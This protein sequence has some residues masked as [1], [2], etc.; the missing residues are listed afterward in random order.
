MNLFVAITDNAWFGQLRA[1]AQTASVAEVNFWR[2]SGVPF[3]ALAVGEP[4]LFK[5][6]APRHVIAGGG[7]FS[8]ASKLS[9]RLAW[10]AFGPY[11]G[12]AS[13]A[14]LRER[15]RKYRGTESDD[16]I[17]CIILS[18]PFFFAPEGCISVPGDFARNLQ[19]GRGYAAET[20]TGRWLYDQVGERLAHAAVMDRGPAQ[21]ALAEA[22]FG[23]PQPVAP[24]LGQGGFRVGML[25]NYRWRCAISGERTVPVLEA[26]HIR[27]YSDGG[28]HDLRNGLLLRS[29][30]HRLFDL[31]YIAIAPEDRRVLVSSRI[32]TEFENGRNY[33][34]LEGKPLATPSELGAAP[35][36]ES[37]RFH[38]EHVYRG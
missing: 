38:L 19:T 14:A 11:N 34:A 37:L 30:L 35:D 5:L 18:E 24:R 29:D 16:P 20:G 23:A 36:P 3:R 6:H 1:M 10:E 9:V 33:Y 27:R 2:P 32:R 22:R 17:T 21:F 12:V 26:A 13:E 8:R 15:I 7:F 4:L 28:G 31:G 25:E